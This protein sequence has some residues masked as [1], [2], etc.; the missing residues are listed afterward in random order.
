[1][2][3]KL[4]L[5]IKPIA[6][7]YTDEK[8]G[9]IMQQHNFN[10]VKKSMLFSGKELILETGK[11]A[12]QANG[13][14]IL[15]Y[16]DTILLV[17]A[18]AAPKA[19]EGQGFFPLTVD[20][21]EKM[22]A[23]GKIPGGFI[24]RESK[25]STNA[26]LMSRVVDRTIRP[27]FPE[28]FLN[29]VHVVVTTLSYDGEADLGTL[30]LIGAS[31]ALSISDIPFHG[32]IA[33]ALVGIIDGEIVVNPTKTDL[34]KSDLE[35]TV[36]GSMNSIVMI[37]SGANEISEE[38]IAD[39]VYAGHDEIKKVISLQEELVKEIGKEKM[40][41]VVDE[42]PE[43]IFNKISNAFSADLKKAIMIKEKLVR[44]EAVEEINEKIKKMIE[45]DLSEEEIEEKAKYY[46]KSFEKLESLLFRETILKDKIRVD[47]RGFDEI[48]PLSMEI[49]LLPRVHGSALFTRGET[50]SIGTVTIGT[51]SDEK[52]MDGLDE[53]YRKKFFLHYN[54]PP[55][56][57]GE[58]GFM[59]A[60]GRRE[61]GHGSLAERA[62][63]PMIP[64]NDVFPYTI[65]VVSDITESN[66]SSSMA[67]VC[68]GSLALMAAGVPIKKPVAGIANGLIMDGDD[69][70]ILTDIQGMEDHLGDMD[71]KVTGT[72]DGI[73]AVQMDIK[74]EG[75]TRAIMIEALSKAKDARLYI[76]KH[77]KEVIEEP[78][79]EL[80]NFAPH[81]ETMQIDPSKIAAVIGPGGKNVKQIIEDTGVSIDID[82]SG[83]IKVAST[84]GKAIKVAMDTI[85]NIAYDPEVNK[86]YEGIVTRVESYGA[87][88]NFMG[89]KKGLVHVSKLVDAR[90]SHP[91]DL[92]KVGDKVNVRFTGMKEGK[93]QLS[94][95]GVEGNPKLPEGYKYVR[96]E[97]PQNDR[98]H[99][100]NNRN[101]HNNRR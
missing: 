19:N 6:C 84:E 61:L 30:G 23:S 52:I 29:A 3:N 66:G 50:Q 97:R 28:G 35:L 33:G 1:M 44:N 39:A 58:A 98:P 91:Q 42:I 4:N 89:Q 74:I 101:Y 14:I 69:F 77:M 38:Q 92:V 96:A 59:R 93:Y 24:K 34:L 13:A 54:F 57:V 45:E 71:F 41:F 73:T 5:T 16:G 26:T 80:S 49:D 100:D 12:K 76:L 53:E 37:E 81:I 43:D 8:K 65:R 67:T 9:D 7:T 83:L 68:S 40:N 18:T 55:Y 72:V 85:K 10:I 88:V 36:G 11:I 75:I 51:G 32:P 56:S 47:G 22:Y 17:T 21:I 70:Q 31:A 95:V 20:F 78:R 90:V 94:M 25:P 2:S 27:L 46:H 48:R 15:K 86:I 63:K 99:R 79:K 62:L 60:P 87:F 82:D 64:D